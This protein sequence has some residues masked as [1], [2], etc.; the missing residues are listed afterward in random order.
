MCQEVCVS[1]DESGMSHE[2]L[3]VLRRCKDI[4]QGCDL[5]QFLKHPRQ[6]WSFLV[7]SEKL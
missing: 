4:G 6:T 2:S 3:I 7:T 5:E 1:R